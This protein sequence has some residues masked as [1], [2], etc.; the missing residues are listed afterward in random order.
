MDGIL[1]LDKPAGMTSFSAVARCRKIFH[2]KKTGHT[3]TLDPEATGL[4]IVLLGKYTKLLPFAVKDHK[5]YHATIRFDI[6]TD[7]D[8]VFGT[9]IEEKAPHNISVEELQKAA[10]AM[11]GEREQIPP[12]VSAIKQNGRKLYEYA[13]KGIEVER[14]PRKVRYDS[15]RVFEEDGVMHLDAVV[16]GGTYIRTLIKDLGEAVGEY[17][18][19]ASLVRTGIESLELSQANSLEE[20]ETSPVF[21]EPK[22]IIDPSLPVLEC[23]FEADVIHGRSILLDRED[24]L[25]LFEKDGE[26]LAAYEKRED[27]RYHCLRGLL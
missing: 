8:D 5:H 22:K 9:V 25:I 3:G 24:P 7:T 20:L 4:M 18:V 13:R 1:L 14:K 21:T 26:L 15:L 10:D 11:I 12:M 23:P 17:A 2:E 6:R 16:S 19:M 27:G